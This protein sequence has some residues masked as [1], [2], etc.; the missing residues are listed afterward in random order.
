MKKF[1]LSLLLISLTSLVLLLAACAAAPRVQTTN[2]SI[3]FKVEK[4]SKPEKA[5]STESAK[6]IYENLIREDAGGDD[7]PADAKI[8][9]HFDII[10]QSKMD[11]P[12]VNFGY[13]SFFRGMHRAY[14][15]HRPFVISPDMI[16]LLIS[17]GFAQ[18]VNANAERLRGRF[19][20]FDGKVSLVVATNTI[21]LNNP[22]APWSDVFPDLMKQIGEHTGG[23][24]IKTLTADFSTTT[25]TEAIASQITIMEATK[26]YFEYVVLSAMCGIPEI[27]L[28]GTPEDWQRVLDKTKRLADYDLAWW[29]SELEPILQEF[30]KASRGEID[31]KF[32]VLRPS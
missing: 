20:N 2:G 8:D 23:E 28:K 4:L 16:W 32:W 30:V 7:M 21:T 25:P 9:Y 29:T 6:Q 3:T 12:L 11:T 19:V 15:E 5:L 17:Q 14:V 18:H 13:N 10:A 26:S 27:T 1:P 31:R 24:L 22:D